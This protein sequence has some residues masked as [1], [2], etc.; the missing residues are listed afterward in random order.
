MRLG[1]DQTASGGEFEERYGF[2]S[3]DGK[4]MIAVG[5]TYDETAGEDGVVFYE[6]VKS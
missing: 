4:P 3:A 2:L 1:T 6:F 5:F